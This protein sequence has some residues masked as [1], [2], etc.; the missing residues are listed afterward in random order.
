[1]SAPEYDFQLPV[2]VRYDECGAQGVVRLS[3]VANWFQEA[4]GF[5]ADT[6]G[7]GNAA[8]GSKTLTWILTRTC[9]RISRLPV[10]GEKITIRTWPSRRERLACR[11]YEISDQQGAVCL[12][13]VGEWAVLD[14]PSR[15]IV[16]FPDVLV[17]RYPANPEPSLSFPGR[18]VPKLR[19]AELS[20]PLLV[21]HDDL[22]INGHVNNAHY[23]S[24]I[25]EPLV[26]RADPSCRLALVDVQFRAETFPLDALESRVSALIPG[27]G[28]AAGQRL[29][30]IVRTA[31]GESAAT[32]VCRAVSY[33]RRGQAPCEKHS[34]S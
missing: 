20:F 32:E 18:V 5:N 22:D 26:A 12:E 28:H 7:F 3:C 19:E 29:H 34:A 27:E 21:R 30:S 33:W 10:F 9:L 31:N 25:L 1:M 2:Q 8:L 14:L 15:H 16:P 6:L 13:A 17:S 24:W 4:A 11:G 23:L